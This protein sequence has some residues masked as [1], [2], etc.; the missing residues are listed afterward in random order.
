MHMK[1]GDGN[2]SG[3]VGGSLSLGLWALARTSLVARGCRGRGGRGARH[4][5]QNCLRWQESCSSAE[6]HQRAGWRE[7][8]AFVLSTIL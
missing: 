4:L 3:N 1:G 5:F 6:A 8:S 2:C 7:I